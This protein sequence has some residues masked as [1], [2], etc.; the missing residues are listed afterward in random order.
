MKSFYLFAVLLFFVAIN[1][2][3]QSSGCPKLDVSAVDSSFWLVPETKAE[4]RVTVDGAVPDRGSFEW[5]I[6]F[7]DKIEGQ[8]SPQVSFFVSEDLEG[9]KLQIKVRS[10][11]MKPGCGDEAILRV[12]VI[13][14]PIGEPLDRIERGLAKPRDYDRYHSAIFSLTKSIETSGRSYNG[15]IEISFQSEE[16]F[17]SRKELLG[18]ILNMLVRHKANLDDV[19]IAFSDGDEEI[20]TFWTVP[21]NAKLPRSVRANGVRIGRA[22]EIRNNIE[23]FLKMQK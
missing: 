11:G 14:L 2:V 8:G 5:S 17:D 10:V 20:S 9:A 4:F 23:N 12:G 22:N 3:A 6:N 19:L 15:L 21:P 7:V 16:S 18:Q 13:Q 1:A